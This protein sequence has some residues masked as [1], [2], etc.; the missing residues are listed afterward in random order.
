MRSDRLNSEAI[1]DF[2]R[3]LCAV[4]R[5]ELRAPGA[6]RVYSLTK[7]VEIAHFNMS[8]IRCCRRTSALRSCSTLRPRARTHG[9][10]GTR[11]L[12]VCICLVSCQDWYQPTGADHTS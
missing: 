3:A 9:V 4:A 11:D 1:V 12:C 2:V 6:P 5:E 7:I 8:R 10:K